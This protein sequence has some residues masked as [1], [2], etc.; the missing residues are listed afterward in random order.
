MQLR[1]Y[2]IQ[3]MFR[4]H[5]GSIPATFREQSGHNQGTFLAYSLETFLGN[6]PVTFREHSG[7]IQGT[8]GERS[9]NTPVTFREHP[10][11]IQG[12]STPAG[13]V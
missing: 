2:K 5:S 12:T 13:T 7:H 6:I 1:N 9:E 11:L 10:G 3:G 4:P 8:L